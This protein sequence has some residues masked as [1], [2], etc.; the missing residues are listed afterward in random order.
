MPKFRDTT[1]HLADRILNGEYVVPSQ[2]MKL[3]LKN[4]ATVRSAASKAAL[5]VYRHKKN[6]MDRLDRNVKR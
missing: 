6:F 5:K 4:S 1:Q 3:L 2:Y